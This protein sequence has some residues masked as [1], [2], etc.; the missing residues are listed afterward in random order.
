MKGSVAVIAIIVVLLVSVAQT[1][2]LGQ[3]VMISSPT[4][5]AIFQ[6]IGGAADIPVAA[7]ASGVP[8]GG[9]VEFVLDDGKPNWRSII[10]PAA[11]YR[12]VF[13]GVLVG[14]HTLDVYVVSSTGSRLALDHAER[15]GVGDVIIAM[16]DSITAGLYDDFVTD[17]WSVDGRTGPWVDPADGDQFGGYAPIL[18]DMLTT[19]RGYPV[20]VL[21]KG[22][23]GDTT[24]DAVSDAYSLALKYPD[25]ATWILAYGTNDANQGISPSTYKSN[26]QTAIKR[27]RQVNPDAVIYLPKVLYWTKAIIQDYHDKAGDIIRTTWGVYWGADL[28]TLFRANHELYSHMPFQQGTWFSP[29]ETHHPNGVGVQ[30]MAMLWRMAL[31]DKAFIVTDGVLS[32]AGGTWA[33]SIH[34]EGADGIGL[35]ESNL[36]QICRSSPQGDPPPGTSFLTLWA[37]DLRLTGASSFSGPLTATVRLEIDNLVRAGAT[38][39]DQV[40]LA[41]NSTLLT[42][43]RAAHPAN[44]RNC[45]FTAD[46]WEPG[47]VACVADVTPPVTV[48]SVTPDIAGGGGVYSSPPQ[49]VLSA[50]DSTGLPV[51]AVMCRWDDAPAEA[52]SGPMTA[53]MG[54]HTL[55]YHAVDQSGNVEQE[56]SVTFRVTGTD[57]APVVTDNARYM[58]KPDPVYVTWS[59]AS[60]VGIAEYRY[61]VGS[62]AGGTDLRNWTSAGTATGVTWADP[63]VSAGTTVYF[64]VVAIGGDGLSSGIGCSDGVTVAARFASIGAAKV[65]ADGVAVSIPQVILN[66]SMGD[67]AYIEQWDRSAAM[68]MRG[69][70]DLAAGR[71]LAVVGRLM[72]IKGQR[73][74]T[75]VEVR[76]SAEYP[77]LSPVS[78]LC[79][80]VRLDS[81]PGALARCSST[82]G[83]LIRVSGTVISGGAGRFRVWDGSTGR[84]RGPLVDANGIGPI[85]AVGS[86]VTV[87][88]VCTAVIESGAWT[89]CLVP[90]SD[91]DIVVI[92]VQ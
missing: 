18:S 91:T 21:N 49:I 39:W 60:A 1:S 23:P 65:M 9:S 86:R 32:G 16:G 88:G 56:K 3:T 20:A 80:F 73:V 13:S 92:S 59:F 7:A 2:A 75:D 78:M 30:K 68:E 55:F 74:L 15:I 76:S 83:M 79:R 12:C 14:E 66:T 38:S 87:T 31:L 84:Q 50:S 77:V 34:V 90:R 17:N 46:V 5:G 72:T 41:S 6:R 53:P 64:S 19:A 89:P 29:T 25:A 47:Q 37:F 70:D 28:D 43:A 10:D 44:L 22:W 27:I 4:T 81:D 42:T 54:V 36:L 24:F 48:C 82:H 85:P 35:S 8:P 33:D 71:S 52:Y 40:W 45:H 63:G 62:Y 11:P 26:L 61:A 67:R 58:V 51:A 57:P 69:V